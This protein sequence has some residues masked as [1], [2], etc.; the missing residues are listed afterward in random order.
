MPKIIFSIFI[1][2]ALIGAWFLYSE[3]YTAEAQKGVEKVSFQIKQDESV[4]AFADRLA[5]EQIVR[6]AWLFKKYLVWKGADTRVNY[7]LFEVAVP[8]TLA[9]VVHALSEP[10]VNERT[11][12]ILPGWNVRDVGAYVEKEGLGTAEEVF[13]LAGRPA[14]KK[15]GSLS[16][17]DGEFRLLKDKSADAGLEGYLRPDTYRIF[18]DASVE[19]IIR[20]LVKER[21]KQFTDEM[22]AAIE[23]SNRTIH[24]IMTMASIL[25][26]EVRTKKDRALVADIFWRRYDL[27]WALQADSTV[28][29]IFGLSGDVF[30]TPEQ[31]ASKNSWNT[32]EYPGLPPGPIS[33]PSLESIMAAIYPEKNSHWYFLTDSQGNVH[34]AETL[35]EHNEN[36]A[37]FL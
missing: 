14:E 30:T 12:T 26:R 27:N 25:E 11:I 21:D 35:K 32:Y 18:N 22:Y 6:N 1:F 36:R 24:E 4:A 29:Y 13:L 7:G 2:C 8:I 28:H 23:K 20:R 16:F 3:I 31:R 19:D 33:N 34:Y 37:R 15:S 10:G 17:S 9:R 5:E